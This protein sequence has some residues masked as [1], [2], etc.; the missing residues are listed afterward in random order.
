MSESP[1]R[2]HWVGPVLDR[3]P[4]ADAVLDALRRENPEA[5]FVDH[6]AYVRVLAPGRCRLSRA[7]VEAQAG[8]PF[9][10]PSDL[11]SVMAAFRG[12]LVVSDDEAVWVHEAGD[13]R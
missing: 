1:E 10:L 9:R 8:R 4:L 11:E 6:G 5:E 3:S 2:A 13:P 7:F 12:R